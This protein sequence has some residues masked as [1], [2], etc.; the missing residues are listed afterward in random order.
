VGLFKLDSSTK[1]V[2]ENISKLNPYESILSN[3]K[4]VID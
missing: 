3:K 4:S 2:I 1:D